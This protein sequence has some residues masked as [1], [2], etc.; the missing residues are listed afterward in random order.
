MSVPVRVRWYRSL[1]SRLALCLAGLMVLSVLLRPVLVDLVYELTGLPSERVAARL[2]LATILGQGLLLDASA[3][4]EGR[5]HPNRERRERIESLLRGSGR[6]FVLLDR[7]DRV[8]TCSAGLGLPAG[9]LWPI[10]DRDH[11]WIDLA[12][13]SDRGE[14]RL[15]AFYAP[16][17]KDGRAIGTFALLHDESVAQSSRSMSVT[18]LTGLPARASST[19]S[20]SKPPSAAVTLVSQRVAESR[21]WRRGI[22]LVLEWLIPLLVV[23]MLSAGI[24]ALVTRRLSVLSA[25]AAEREGESLPGPFPAGGQDEIAVLGA[26]LNEL[27]NHVQR[28]LADRDRRMQED[29]AWVAQVSHDLRTPLT[30]LLACLERA[31]QARGGELAEVLQTAR[32]DALRVYDLAEGLLDIAR[33]DSG[34]P[35]RV[36][37]LHP[38][39]IMSQVRR[40]LSPIAASTGLRI[41]MSIEPEL[42]QIWADGQRLLRVLENL[43]RNGIHHARDTVTMCARRSASGVELAVAD[44]GTGFAGQSGEVDLERLAQN[45]AGS[46]HSTGIGLQVARRIAVAHGSSLLA[47]N[48]DT[49]GARVGLV[50]GTGE[51]PGGASSES[52]ATSTANSDPPA[53]AASGSRT[54]AS[55][56]RS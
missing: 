40:T 10:R 1:T 46:G 17:H 20:S 23:L 9:R 26:T 36:E 8:V 28:L 25:A 48:L 21:R 35:L 34:E 45:G 33:L 2:D 27:R 13:L 30:A 24:A 56:S 16:M 6:K 32:L 5:L 38:E 7:E 52:T 11:E 29:R 55:R 22:A 44:D 43:V 18:S 15:H 3:D 51:I 50:L 37:L 4:D 14:E 53:A 31:K 47:R 49:G 12:E 19:S 41:E 42:P 54:R 39:E